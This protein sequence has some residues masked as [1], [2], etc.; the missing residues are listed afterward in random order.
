M[1]AKKLNKPACST[2]I[3]PLTKASKNNV[4]GYVMVGHCA[5]Y[6]PEFSSIN[7][8]KTKEKFCA[9]EGNV[10][11]L[12]VIPMNALIS[13]KN[14]DKLWSKISEIRKPI[15]FSRPQTASNYPFYGCTSTRDTNKDIEAKTI[16]ETK[17]QSNDSS[18]SGNHKSISK[19]ILN[20]ILSS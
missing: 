12:S 4:D 13:H 18:I 3:L 1:A 9:S 11:L 15:N 20:V 10:D 17:K 14:H 2:K 5:V 6:E 7:Q 8:K 16:V 19:G